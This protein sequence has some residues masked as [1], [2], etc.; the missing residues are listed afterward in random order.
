MSLGPTY[1][2]ADD[3]EFYKDPTISGHDFFI[4][5]DEDDPPELVIMKNDRDSDSLAKRAEEIIKNLGLNAK[6]T[7]KVEMY[8]QRCF[9]KGYNFKDAY[10]V[11]I[12]IDSPIPFGIITEHEGKYKGKGEATFETCESDFD[13]PAWKKKKFGI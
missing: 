11:F 2:R 1:V 7:N 13:F 8:I 10:S 4:C 5:F 9:G 6:T 12:E 3:D